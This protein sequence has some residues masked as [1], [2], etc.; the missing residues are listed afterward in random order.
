MKK[1]FLLVL[2]PFLLPA[3]EGVIK[4]YYSD[5]KIESEITYLNGIREGEAKFYNSEGFLKEERFYISGRVE[6]LGKSI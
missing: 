6:G 3:Q 2:I 4:N 5:G 1:I